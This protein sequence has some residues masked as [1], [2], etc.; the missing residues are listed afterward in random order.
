M[1]DAFRHAPS[2]RNVAC[3]DI[4]EEGYVLQ[5]VLCC[6]ARRLDPLYAAPAGSLAQ[7]SQL[8]HYAMCQ[9]F[10][11]AHHGVLFVVVA[12]LHVALCHSSLR[13]L[14]W[15]GMHLFVAHLLRTC[16]ASVAISHT[17][18]HS[19]AYRFVCVMQQHACTQLI[20]ITMC[21]M[22]GHAQNGVL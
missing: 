14:R 3:V 12:P 9:T 17:A 8:L 5:V 20:H 2:D 6:A 4:F 15:H 19:Y 21:Q 16:C 1:L 10:A 13:H 7:R 22:F 18:A 11:Y